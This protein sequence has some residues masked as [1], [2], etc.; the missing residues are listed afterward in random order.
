MSGCGDEVSRR[1]G[2]RVLGEALS[3]DLRTERGG[4]EGVMHTQWEKDLGEWRQD[5]SC[6]ASVLILSSVMGTWKSSIG[7][8]SE[9]TR[10]KWI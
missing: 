4:G 5:E 8:I 3:E 6:S 2:E 7:R 1:S 9:L 10:S